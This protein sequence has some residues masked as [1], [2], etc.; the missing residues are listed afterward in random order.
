MYQL[1]KLIGNTLQMVF[2]LSLEL[3][4]WTKSWQRISRSL[5]NWQ[6]LPYR[7]GSGATFGVQNIEG[8]LISVLRKVCCNRVACYERAIPRGA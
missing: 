5:V 6:T 1:D 4:Q 7:L 8:V 3:I 2:E